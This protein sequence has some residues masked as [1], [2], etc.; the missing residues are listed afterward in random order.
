MGLTTIQI[1]FNIN[2]SYPSLGALLL[3]LEPGITAEKLKVDLTD[4]EYIGPLGV[5]VLSSLAATRKE[6]ELETVM[7]PPKLARANN[8]CIYAGLAS[9]LGFGRAPDQEHP[10][11]ETMALRVFQDRDQTGVLQVCS[12]VKK[13]ILLTN[14]AS[15]A[16]STMVGELTQNVS[17]HAGTPGTL[18]ARFLRKKAVVRVAVADFGIGLEQHLN[19]KHK[20]HGPIHALR[21]ALEQGRTSGT[22]PHNR[23]QG[24]NL[25]DTLV[26]HNGGRMLLV[27]GGAYYERRRDGWSTLKEFQRGANLPGTL[28]YFEFRVNCDLYPDED[29]DEDLW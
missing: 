24:L 19:L 2:D 27:S 15:T 7:T 29:S 13:H 25:L 1:D 18:T 16:L 8:Y 10:K 3:R 21:L 20:V 22:A 12:L 26:V 28:C 6:Q 4:C 17:D 11:N 23:G 14:H 9:Q 5:A